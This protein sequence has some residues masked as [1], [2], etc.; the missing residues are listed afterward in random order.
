MARIVSAPVMLLASIIFTSCV[1]DATAA[2]TAPRQ[3]PGSF[4][5]SPGGAATYS[6]PIELPQAAGGGAPHL[7]V[8][9]DSQ[10]GD[11]FFG[12]GWTLRGLS[13][14]TRCPPPGQ[15]AST[16]GAAPDEFCL[17]GQRL[18]AIQKSSLASGMKYRTEVDSFIEV[19]SEG[20]CEGGPCAF[21]ASWPDGR[22][23]RYD[24]PPISRGSK[25]RTR[26]LWTLSASSDK[27]GN[28]FDVQYSDAASDSSV[29]YF[30]KVIE[31]GKNRGDGSRPFY[32]I[33][34]G[35]HS[36][37]GARGYQWGVAY[38][39]TARIDL[40][41]VELVDE[42]GARQV[43]SYD[44]AYERSES[45]RD[46]LISVTRCAE[47]G[48]CT[49]PT[50]FEWSQD[51]ASVGCGG[52]RP[53][54]CH[55]FQNKIQ[56]LSAG[57]WKKDSV[58]FSGDFNGD[59]RTDIAQISPT[60]NKNEFKIQL[61]RASTSKIFAVAKDV[62]Q[63]FDTP[64]GMFASGDF[65][66]DGRQEIAFIYEKL[67]RWTIDPNQREVNIVVLK[68]DNNKFV[69]AASK[70][71]DI[72]V[73][74]IFNVS[75]DVKNQLFMGGG[76]DGSGTTNILDFRLIEGGEAIVDVFRSVPTSGD[77]HFKRENW[78]KR[79]IDLSDDDLAK[80]KVLSGDFNGDGYQDLAL[81]YPKKGK[82][83]I[84]VLLSTGSGFER[85]TWLDAAQSDVNWDDNRQYLVFDHNGDGLTDI[86]GDSRDSDQMPVFTSTQAAFR[87][88][89]LSRT[90][91][92]GSQTPTLGNFT[93]TGKA[94]LA[95][96]Y[97]P[98]GG[99]SAPYSIDVI[100]FSTNVHGDTQFL[101]DATRIGWIRPRARG[102]AWNTIVA[103]LAGDYSGRGVDDLAVL[104]NDGGK[105]RIEI[106]STGLPRPDRLV[107]IKKGDESAIT[108]TY[109]T[110]A[111]RKVYERGARRSDVTDQNFVSS[112]YG[113]VAEYRIEAQGNDSGTEAA[114]F[115]YRYG[116]AR[117][118]Q[119]VR[120]V[121]GFKWMEVTDRR[122][123]GKVTTVYKQPFPFTTRVEKVTVS[124]GGNSSEQ[125]FEYDCVSAAK[126]DGCT[127]KTTEGRFAGVYQVT[128][129][130]VSTREYG[131]AGQYAA[132]VTEFE[133]DAKGNVVRETE[134]TPSGVSRCRTYGAVGGAEVIVAEKT[135]RGRTCGDMGRWDEASDLRWRQLAHDGHGNVVTLREWLA[136]DTGRDD[137]CGDAKQQDGGKWVC[138]A[139]AYDVAG[140]V[141]AV[142][143]PLG[144]VSRYQYDAT[145]AHRTG[146]ETPPAADGKPLRQRIVVDPPSGLATSV[147]D[148]NDVTTSMVYDGFGRPTEVGMTPPQGGAKVAVAQFRYLTGTRGGVVTLARSCVDWS[149]CGADENWMTA[150]ITAAKNG[151]PALPARG[152]WVTEVTETDVSG[153]VVLRGLDDGAG[154]RSLTETEYDQFGRV[155]GA[156]LPRLDG[157]EKQAVKYT[158]D[159]DGFLSRIE[160][161][162]GR[163]RLRA[164]APVDNAETVVEYRTLQ[165]GRKTAQRTTTTKFDGSGRPAEITAPDGVTTYTY[166]I[167]GQKTSEKSP[168]RGNVL[169][170]YDSLGR[171]VKE[172][173]TTAGTKTY[174]YDS[175]GRL[176]MVGDGS[177][178]TVS[179][180]YD[181][182]GR[183]VHKR[184][185][186]ALGAATFRYDQ[187]DNGRGRLTA[188]ET[189]GTTYTFA[190]DAH[191]NLAKRTA[192]LPELSGRYAFSWQHD[193]WGRVI[194]A[195]YPDGSVAESVYGASLDLQDVRLTREG[196]LDAQA[197]FMRY[198]AEG[199]VGDVYQGDR[200]ITQHKFDPLGRQDKLITI[201]ESAS[202]P[203]R[204]GIEYM[205]ERDGSTPGMLTAIR[206][207]AAQKDIL[208]FFYDGYGRP[209]KQVDPEGSFT[210]RYRDD[211][212]DWRITGADDHG[213]AFEIA[214][215]DR[216]PQRI[217]SLTSKLNGS[218]PAEYSEIGMLTRL[219]PLSISADA[220]GRPAEIRSETNVV[221]R[222][223]YDAFGQ[224]VVAH[225]GAAT[226]WSVAPDYVV[227]RGSDGK[228]V[229]T[230]TPY[231]PNGPV[232]E[233]T[234]EGAGGSPM[235]GWITREGGFRQGDV[236]AR[237]LP[238]PLQGG[239]VAIVFA[240]LM[241][242]RWAAAGVLARR[243][244]QVTVAIVVTALL[245]VSP[246]PPAVAAPVD[247]GS[248][249]GIPEPGTRYLLTDS[250][251]HILSVFDA[252]TGDEVERFMPSYLRGPAA[253]DRVDTPEI[254]EMLALYGVNLPGRGLR[255]SNGAAARSAQSLE[256]I[257]VVD[258][259]SIF[260]DADPNHRDGRQS[261]SHPSGDMPGP[262]V[263]DAAVNGALAFFA[264]AVTLATI[265]AGM[266]IAAGAALFKA[267]TIAAAFAI[268]WP[269][270]LAAVIVAAVTVAI[271]LIFRSGTVIPGNSKGLSCI[272]SGGASPGA[273]ARRQPI[274]VSPP[275]QWGK[276]LE[277]WRDY[278]Q[279]IPVLV[280][281]T[282][283][284]GLTRPGGSGRYG[285][286]RGG[287]FRT[288]GGEGGG[289][290]SG[291]GSGATGGSGV[292]TTVVNSPIVG[293]GLTAISV[294]QSSYDAYGQFGFL[295]A[296]GTFFVQGLV[297]WHGLNMWEG[298][299]W[300][301]NRHFLRGGSPY[302]WLS[303]VNLS[304][305]IFFPGRW[306]W[307]YSQ[308]PPTNPRGPTQ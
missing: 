70:V 86:F 229:H 12:V 223:D 257:V 213:D 151:M 159:T 62:K 55:P 59:G 286:P 99:K 216:R 289:S 107:K 39:K 180:G 4:S 144:N 31:Y 256:P 98:D 36:G 185:S 172:T 197:K 226:A 140:N 94:D 235:L 247:D 178:T 106:N 111:D 254:R 58:A 290:G 191:G 67:H 9:Y 145:S 270:V 11:G 152:G 183:P 194:K 34:F 237:A 166:D 83:A 66:G 35:V 243:A 299:M 29:E 297:G 284:G 95:Y 81:V 16:T 274:L 54:A 188:A 47:N 279:T 103:T 250:A 24:A 231:G 21:T 156:G 169:Y 110:L 134:I 193:P 1:A 201:A 184:S 48:A 71:D 79:N 199:K 25:D 69:E 105:L 116:D 259:N 210:A 208:S 30:P 118:D 37:R 18:I 181:A 160:S 252:A 78:F 261:P 52:N 147:A 14:V 281:G 171:L 204:R 51:L 157:G 92:N 53:T 20:D 203:M 239:V 56:T 280:D 221:G 251:G 269:V 241:V 200:L 57:E 117:I 91:R 40:M 242:V 154:S 182:L 139:F 230:I 138:T 283:T 119:K 272:A 207:I 293:G 93:G 82:V 224:R 135:V 217:N 136:Q 170:A 108:V 165:G 258:P 65:T 13:A 115:G 64:G 128:P 7:D 225:H 305:A 186:A 162:G 294:V 46:H 179:F 120:G 175:A 267:L 121:L 60:E 143:D 114:S 77:V 176:V 240:L 307:R 205:W 190:Y 219:G 27:N 304:L 222:I 49:E 296:L 5:V 236:L 73:S 80:V 133:S 23:A 228:F 287:N 61:L 97:K 17:D 26:A 122:D 68:Y 148:P 149:K 192:S 129:S 45:R 146:V 308:R 44:F 282:E 218:L 234:R 214:Y 8:A 273:V 227:M 298:Y 238:S 38:S 262:G 232:A 264:T 167:L 127:V 124:R 277:V 90:P 300:E 209:I 303:F 72:P 85:K 28:Y 198:D 42:R 233:V 125:A 202:G 100:P 63:A 43:G 113:V 89:I 15:P 174:A 131:A 246:M 285:L 278:A 288:H 19:R 173:S 141:V 88:E 87:A 292:V 153:R 291:P 130:K 6:I 268:S 244:A 245:L 10:G 102:A 275:T 41:V 220:M 3:L 276:E 132:T 211:P 164:R 96:V 263:G 22:Q 260:N 253:E 50:R 74:G 195:V 109:A 33:R 158:Y 155:T 249:A 32:R 295:S 206:D 76:F 104:V 302:R 271:I 301:R 196:V 75:K 123:G 84:D 212:R 137:A 187:G 161:P 306:F 265:K 177:G 126:A 150:P 112:Q 266:A 101:D 215:D 142:T 248:S 189:G 168:A 255:P 163:V 2:A